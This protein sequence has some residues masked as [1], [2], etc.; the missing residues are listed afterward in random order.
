MEAFDYT[1]LVLVSNM[2]AGMAKDEIL[3]TFSVKR[4]D[5]SAD[6]A[7]YFDE[8]YAYGR[9]MT[10]HKVIMNLVESTKG[11][12]GQAA[13]LAYLRRFAKEFEEDIDS[14]GDTSGNFSFSFG[15]AE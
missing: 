9:G 6:E 11:R 8:F 12:A 14:G 13:A 3:D 10:K 4:E 2:A 15:K 1:D 7:I 5:L